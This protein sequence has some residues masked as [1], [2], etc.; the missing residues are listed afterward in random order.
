MSVTP[1]SPRTSRRWRWRTPNAL[2]TRTTLNPTG[3]LI[4]T[5]GLSGKQSER[6][7]PQEIE[8]V[9]LVRRSKQDR[10]ALALRL[11]SGKRVLIKVQGAA[12]W[13]YDVEQLCGFTTQQ[14]VVPREDRAPL[15][16]TSEEEP[17]DRTSAEW[18]SVKSMLDE[19][20]YPF[21]TG[22]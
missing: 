21:Q 12:L 10:A 11:R 5:W 18:K 20:D 16:F 19:D 17:G 22:A 14:A 4:E 9:S 3:F 13:K 6:I 1:F 15:Q 8:S 2:L 7:A